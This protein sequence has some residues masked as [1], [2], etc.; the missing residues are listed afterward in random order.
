MRSVTGSFAASVPFRGEG[1]IF[2]SGRG[3]IVMLSRE[4][5]PDKCA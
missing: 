4:P 2:T 5:S 1:S 3:L